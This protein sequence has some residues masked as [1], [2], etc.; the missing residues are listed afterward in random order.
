MSL[1]L[2]RYGELGL[3]APGTRRR[4]EQ[5]LADNLLQRLALAGIEARIE[6]HHRNAVALHAGLEAL[7]L[8]L[9]VPQESRLDQITPLWIPEGID[10][11]EVRQALLRDYRI[12]IGRGLGDF[13]G[14]AWRIGLMGENSKPA[15]VLTLL[16]ALEKIL[17][18]EGY[19]VAQG[20]GVSAAEQKLGE[21]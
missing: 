13:A 9:V 15:A 16:S 18:Q 20:Q 6:R 12:E 10:D 7:G 21:P 14:K 19:E 1:F 3:K 5:K 2:L 11:L 4:Y 17:P 8:Q